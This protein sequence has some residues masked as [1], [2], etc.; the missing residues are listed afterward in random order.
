MY[1]KLKSCIQVDKGHLGKSFSCNI[2]TRQGCMLSPF[3]FIFYLNELISMSEQNTCKGIFL[4]ETFSNVPMLMYA[5]DLVIM[6]DTIGNVQKLLDTLSEFCDKW[7]LFVNMDKTKL[8]VFRNGG[9]IKQNEVVYLNGIKLDCVSYYKYLGI[10]IS[11]RLSWSP[12]QT[13]LAAQAS[14]SQAVINQL[15]HKCNYS[16]KTSC[17]L[18]D[19]CTVPVLTYGSEVWGTDVNICIENVQ[20]KFCKSE[21][22]VGSKAATLAVLGECGRNHLSIL[23]NI[24]AISFW[25]KLLSLPDENLVKSCYNLLYVQC[26]RG[27][28]N[29]ASRI[30]QLLFQYGYGYAWLN[31]QIEDKNIFIKLFKT[32]LIDC[33]TQLW[34]A[35][36]NEMSKLSVFRIFKTDL[37]VEM[38]LL[39][40]I[41]R[42]L[43]VAL[44]KFR[45]S[46]HELEIEL[47]RQSNI[48]RG[49]RIC[50]LC[51]LNNKNC[52]ESEFHVLFECATYSD[53]RKLY[54]GKEITDLINLH[55]FKNLMS[56]KEENVIVRL[57]NFIYNMFMVR[58]CSLRDL[59]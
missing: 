49:N 9:I 57:A 53:L 5:D 18:F 12:A 56:T 16:F 55:S 40:N 54:I 19:K 59:L 1:S 26:E 6:G 25:I 22:G 7:G 27:K 38:Y 21:L 14:K 13:T 58:N 28:K 35:N 3:L 29:W 48:E 33:D 44:A 23:C 30:K 24:K 31:Q 34:K 45:I 32:T 10:I 52:I 50:K 46:N 8:M 2:G 20:L 37:C 15:N 42:R 43:R 17:Q 36:L 11:S 47:G 4:N 39:L 51:K 41:P